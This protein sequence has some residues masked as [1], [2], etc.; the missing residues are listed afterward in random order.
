MSEEMITFSISPG[1]GMMDVLGHSGYT[2]NY[3][4]ADILDNC[5]SAHAKN[6]NIFF[7]L[8]SKGPYLYILDDGDGMSFDDLKHAAVIGYKDINEK[9]DGDDL[10]RYSTGLKSATKS[11]CDDIVISSKCSNG[12][13]NSI[14]IDYAHIRESKKWEG[15]VLKGFG[16]EKEIGSHGTLVCCKRLHFVNDLSSNAQVDA[17]LDGL[18]KS[19]G[20]IFGKFLLSGEL[21]VSIQVKGSIQREIEGWN[22]FGLIENKSTKVV[23]NDSRKYKG[24]DVSF[25]AYVLPTFNNL[26]KIDQKYMSGNGLIDQEGFYIYRNK[27]L[28]KEGGWLGLDKLGLDDKCKY[29]RIEVNIP[30]ALDEYFKINF[31]KNSLDIPEELKS[32]FYDVAIKARKE[33]KT[34]F[35]YQKHP[36]IKRTTKKEEE[37]IWRAS[38][39]GG[40]LVLSVNMQHPLIRE[41]STKLTESELKKLCNVLT[42]SLPISMIQEQGTTTIAYTECELEELMEEMYQKLISNNIDIKEVKKRMANME[43]FKENINLLIQFF[44]AKEEENDDK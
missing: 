8:A 19:I 43:P 33:S 12:K 35:N 1:T 10:G 18:E 5:I 6:I 2:F 31:S 20:H 9:R 44:D 17:K 11:F 21:R 22:P 16:L 23:Y 27:R 30:S 29:A 41:L 38:K 32:V 4:M 37:R 25:K 7:D 3:A 15:F 14:E 34:N 42:K 36:E 26:S 13:C 39:S 24:H 28:I 40:G